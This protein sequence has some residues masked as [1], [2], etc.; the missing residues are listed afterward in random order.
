M[1]VYSKSNKGYDLKWNRQDYTLKPKALTELPKDVVEA[2]FGYGVN[3]ETEQEARYLFKILAQRWWQSH[4]SLSADDVDRILKVND[5]NGM[6]LVNESH[7][8]IVNN[9]KEMKS[10]AK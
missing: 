5:E 10:G 9:I 4:P 1:W 6:F 7:D 8:E 2:L 3:T